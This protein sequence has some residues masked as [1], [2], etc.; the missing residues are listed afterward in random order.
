MTGLTLTEK[1]K[2]WIEFQSKC[3]VPKN[4]GPATGLSS[5]KA[6]LCLI[7]I[8]IK[9]DLKSTYRL[10]FYGW[11]RGDGYVARFQFSFYVK[12]DAIR[13]LMYLLVSAINHCWPINRSPNT[14]LSLK[15][16]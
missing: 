16:S 9:C 7:Q 2:I 12:F 10:L 3:T 4:V 1:C 14:L 15:T 6:V 5:L 11:R 8:F 13:P